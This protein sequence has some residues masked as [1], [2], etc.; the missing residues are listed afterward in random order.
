MRHGVIFLRTLISLTFCVASYAHAGK[1]EDTLLSLGA[2]P[3][4]P[5]M[6]NPAL[7]NLNLK[8]A[9]T[10]KGLVYFD[11]DKGIY[12]TT[13]K[14]FIEKDGQMSFV[15]AGLYEHYVNNVQN[16]IIAKSPNEKIMV[17]MY[18]DITCG[19]CQSVHNNLQNYLNQ[20]ISFR[21]LLFPREGL[22]SQVAKQMS[23]IIES[24]NP[25][26]QLQAAFQGQFVQPAPF[27]SEKIVAMYESGNGIDLGGT[28]FFVI[29]GRPFEGRLLP[30]QIIDAVKK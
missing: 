10:D 20:G 4:S 19:Y 24:S 16:A 1:G 23:T 12:F 2:K 5:L 18:T 15:D 26:E 17:T 30:E 6:S 7:Q 14:P 29:N 28:P 27:V 9:F 3:G 25:L 21:F 13:T 8:T 11:E 22:Q